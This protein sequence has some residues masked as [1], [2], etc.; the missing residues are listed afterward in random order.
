MTEGHSGEELTPGEE[1]LNKELMAARMAIDL[2]R[3]EWVEHYYEG[4]DPGDPTAYE[5]AVIT[6]TRKYHDDWDIPEETGLK[7]EVFVMAVEKAEEYLELVKA[8]VAY[9]RGVEELNRA[10]VDFRGEEEQDS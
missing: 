6:V 7:A 5:E 10:L 9:V 3:K 2:T 4:Q 8:E 1:Q